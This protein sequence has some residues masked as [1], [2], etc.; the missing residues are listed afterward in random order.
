[1]KYAVLIVR[2]A[3]DD[4]E[5]IY[6]WLA[7]RSPLGAARWFEAFLNAVSRVKNDPLACA[8]AYESKS[9]DRKVRERIFRTQHGQ[10]YRLLF[11]IIGRKVRVLRVRAP[12]QPPIRRDDLRS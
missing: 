3:V 6:G 1:M 2:D 4:A 5:Q 11:E 7:Q 10:P 9:L 8:F 12:G